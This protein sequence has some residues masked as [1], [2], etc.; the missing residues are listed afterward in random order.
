MVSPPD[1][2]SGGQPDRPN[3]MRPVLGGRTAWIVLTVGQFAAV[4]AVLQR[5]SLGLAAT[6]AFARFG[7]AAATLRHSRATLR[8]SR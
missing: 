6:D 7:I 5:S 8:H 3:G 2:P 4:V 1:H